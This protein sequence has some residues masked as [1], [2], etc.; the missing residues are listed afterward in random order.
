MPG[1]AGAVAAAAVPQADEAHLGRAQRQRRVQQP[2]VAAL[3]G[4]RAG[5]Q[6]PQFGRHLARRF[7]HRCLQRVIAVAPRRAVGRRHHR[8]LDELGFGQRQQQ[9]YAHAAARAGLGKDQ[10]AAGRALRERDVRAADLHLVEHA[11]DRGRGLRRHRRREARPR[12]AGC[13]DHVARKQQHLARQL[14]RHRARDLAVD[15]RQRRRRLG[16]A[17]RQI[18]QQRQRVPR[19]VERE[20]VALGRRRHDAVLAHHGGQ[21]VEQQAQ[22]GIAGLGPVVLGFALLRRKRRPEHAAGQ[23][24]QQGARDL[25][26][27][28]LQQQVQGQRVDA[29]IVVRGVG[30]EG[31]VVGF[32]GFFQAGQ[33]EARRRAPGSRR[34]AV[35]APARQPA[36]LLDAP[37]QGPGLGVAR[38]VF[39]ELARRFVRLLVAA[40]TA[41]ADD[42]PA[43]RHRVGG[44]QRQGVVE[45]LQRKRE[46]AQLHQAAAGVALGLQPQRLRRRLVGEHEDVAGAALLPRHFH[47]AAPLLVGG[48]EL[49]A[50]GEQQLAP[51]RFAQVRQ[52]QVHRA[53]LALRRGLQRGARHRRQRGAV[54]G[55]PGRVGRTVLEAVAQLAVGVDVEG[56]R[57]PRP[58]HQHDTARTQGV[59]HAEFVPDVGVVQRQVG[60]H[61]VGGQQLLEHV[62]AD[63]AGALFLVG[64]EDAAAGVLQRRFQQLGEDA[65]EVD[66]RAV[67]A[68][69]GAE[70]HGDEGVRLHG[71]QHGTARRCAGAAG[72]RITPPPRRRR[73]RAGR[74]AARPRRGAR[75][76]ARAPAPAPARNA[77]GRPPCARAWPNRR[78][79]GRRRSRR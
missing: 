49:V 70:G 24:V 5:R 75:R 36:V 77:P 71:L 34:G 42:A 55:Q 37:G 59:A 21:R 28:V 40:D 16:R 15:D 65:V 38:P 20:P 32:D 2:L 45:L 10:V 67:G 33:F 46:L 9:L 72:W 14:R 44:V 22:F 41:Q 3:E 54:V 13:V 27:Q 11:F 43:A 31:L 26:A 74:P 79:R 47:A 18:L 12:P 50:V 48:T 57:R 7:G 56:A 60:Q 68:G 8:R 73:S 4:I 63:V 29:R 51:G 23:V 76:P 78:G 30:Q 25:A 1:A 17:E 35:A 69:L 19:R 6:G 64:A 66:R 62:A 39:G 53:Q 61:Q 58:L 52:Q